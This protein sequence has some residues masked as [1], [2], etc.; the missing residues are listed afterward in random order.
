M[1]VAKR[2]YT[3]GKAQR[4]KSSNTIDLLFR[5]G[6]SVQQFPVRFLYMQ[7][8]EAGQMQVAVAVSKRFFQKAVHRNKIKRHLREAWR[9][10]KWQLEEICTEKKISIAGMIVFTGKNLND[11]ENLTASMQQIIKKLGINFRGK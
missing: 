11:A 4:L 3:Y 10:Q 5:E 1:A 9:L 7:L 8:P 6:K 2:R